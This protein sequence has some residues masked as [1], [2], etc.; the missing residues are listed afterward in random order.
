L[1]GA[2][3]IFT[4][5]SPLAGVGESRDST[6][7]TYA[8][9]PCVSYTAAFIFFFIDLPA[10]GSSRVRERSAN[11]QPVWRDDFICLA[12]WNARRAVRHDRELHF[13]DSKNSRWL[14]WE[15]LCAHRRWYR[16]G[17]G[18]CRF[19]CHLGW[20]ESCGAAT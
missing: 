8:G 3:R 10:T 7:K 12:D 9:F 6:R 15:R 18:C 17:H 20:A 11:P 4:T 5:A 13:R 16:V 19:I 14:L 1:I 2:A